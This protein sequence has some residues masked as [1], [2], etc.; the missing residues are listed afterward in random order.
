MPHQIGVDNS[1]TVYRH[2]DGQTH[3]VL[4]KQ[5]PGQIKS[6]VLQNG[7]VRVGMAA[8]GGRH[9]AADAGQVTKEQM[10][11]MGGKGVGC[12]LLTLAGQQADLL[13]R[14]GDRTPPVIVRVESVR[15]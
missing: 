11:V 2:A 13:K 10:H 8:A 9:I 1:G 3:S 4:L 12:G 6:E 14:Q 7:G 5:F 15:A